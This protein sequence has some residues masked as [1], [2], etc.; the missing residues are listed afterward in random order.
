MEENKACAF[1]ESFKLKEM[2]DEEFEEWAE[3]VS[4]RHNR[5]VELCEVSDFNTII[6][7]MGG[8]NSSFTPLL[9]VMMLFGT[10]NYSKRV[11]KE[12]I[13]IEYSYMKNPNYL[14]KMNE[15]FI[16]ELKELIK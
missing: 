6:A 11:T 4:E 16:K 13:M 1:I 10:P 12:D 7:E 9:I 2:T 8:L 5:I 3:K 15:N 14:I